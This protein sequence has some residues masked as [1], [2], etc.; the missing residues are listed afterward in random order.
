MKTISVELAKALVNAGCK[1]RPTYEGR[2]MAPQC[3]GIVLYSLTNLAKLALDLPSSVSEEFR[4]V[5]NNVSYDTLGFNMIVY[6]RAYQ[7]PQ[8]VKC[9]ELD[10]DPAY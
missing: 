1:I 9:P 4:R 6:F 8:S 7:W 10:E 3:F 5:L 2:G